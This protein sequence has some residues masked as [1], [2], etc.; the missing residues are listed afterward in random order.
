MTVTEYAV[1]GE[2]PEMVHEVAAAAVVQAAPPG[3][4]VAVYEVIGDPPFSEGAAHD[5]SAVVIPGAT[6]RPVGWPGGVLTSLAWP[7]SQSR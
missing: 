5:T 1:P 4:A 3:D 6:V 2:S 7:R